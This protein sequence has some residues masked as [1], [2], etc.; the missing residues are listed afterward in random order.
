MVVLEAAPPTIRQF[1][2]AHL[3]IEKMHQ[4]PLRDPSTN[5]TTILIRTIFSILICG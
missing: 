3:I 5:A 1:L 2:F 4:H